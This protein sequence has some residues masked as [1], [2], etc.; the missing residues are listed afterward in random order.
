MAVAKV[1]GLENYAKL[2]PITVGLPH[3]EAYA[4]LMSGK[5]EIRSHLASAP[6]S[7]QE[8]NNPSVHRVLS[9]R[10]FVGPMSILLVMTPLAFA[11]ANPALMQAVL[12]AQEEAVG[13]IKD[14]PEGAVTSYLRATQLH[15]PRAE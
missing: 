11:N 7:Y 8:L 15:V 13:I 12:A 9:T 3:P 2:D 4:A 14:D 1:F 5:T 6:F 10:E